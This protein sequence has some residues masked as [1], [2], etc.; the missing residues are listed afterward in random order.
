MSTGPLRELSNS[1]ELLMMLK[2]GLQLLLSD[3]DNGDDDDDDDVNV[4]VLMKM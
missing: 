2:A 4:D 3:Y 1:S